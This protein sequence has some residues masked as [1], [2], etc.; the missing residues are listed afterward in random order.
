MH[1]SVGYPK[2]DP[3]QRQKIKK[4]KGIAVTTYIPPKESGLSKLVFKASAELVP[5][6][7]VPESLALNFLW[8]NCNNS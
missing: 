8:T 1:R 6:F 4:H 7:S 2:M 3:I 5:S